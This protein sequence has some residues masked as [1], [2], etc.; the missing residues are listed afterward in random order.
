MY[1]VESCWEKEDF[2]LG[3]N[4]KEIG[5]VFLDN[6]FTAV[7]SILWL[8]LLSLLFCFGQCQ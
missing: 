3:G 4:D 8:I 6:A 7:L 1:D 5:I 2:I